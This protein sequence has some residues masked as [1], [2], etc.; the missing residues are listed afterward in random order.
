MP[1]LV[2][3][4]QAKPIIVAASG[5]ATGTATWFLVWGEHLRLALAL[6]AGFFGLLCT[7]ATFLLITPRLLRF[8]RAWRARGLTEADKDV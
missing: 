1:G 4:A 8:I 6:A 5:A 2:S 7:A 3:S